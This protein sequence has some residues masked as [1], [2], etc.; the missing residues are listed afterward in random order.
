MAQGTGVFFFFWPSSLHLILQRRLS[1]WKRTALCFYP[2]LSVIHLR[3]WCHKHS[4][5]FNISTQCIVMFCNQEDTNILYF[6]RWVTRGRYGVLSLI[7]SPCAGMHHQSGYCCISQGRTPQGKGTFVSLPWSKPLPAQQVCL[8]LCQQYSA[9]WI[10]KGRSSPGSRWGFSQ[11]HCCQTYPCLGPLPHPI[12]PTLYI[13]LPVVAG[14]RC[15]LPY[16]TGP[17]I[18]P[19]CSQPTHPDITFCNC[20]KMCDVA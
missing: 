16:G 20:Q 6:N 7:P 13:L 15:P 9:V 3:T 18:T 11:W 19:G 2:P 10:H 5:T 4:H 8:N 17:F 12:L 14:G 1:W